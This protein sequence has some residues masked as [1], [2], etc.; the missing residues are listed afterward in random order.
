MNQ[1]IESAAA[2]LTIWGSIATL[3]ADAVKWLSANSATV[4]SITLIIGLLV[5]CWASRR[6]NNRAEE[7]NRRA[8]EEHRLK[9]RILLGEIPDRRSETRNES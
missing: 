5:Q 2:G 8:E 4:T 7:N 1:R 9:M 3:F 6:N